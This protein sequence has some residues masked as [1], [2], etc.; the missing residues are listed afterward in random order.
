[1]TAIRHERPWKDWEDKDQPFREPIAISQVAATATDAWFQWFE[2]TYV[3]SR[4]A[5]ATETLI[6]S[7]ELAC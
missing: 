5:K 7:F 1:M 4:G 2:F 3:V 6:A